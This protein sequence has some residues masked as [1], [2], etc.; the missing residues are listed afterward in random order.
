MLYTQEQ[1]QALHSQRYAFI[2]LEERDH[3]LW[4]T[5]QRPEKKNALHPV[6]I[7]ELAFA[8]HYAHFTTD[9]WTV[10]LR[11]QGDVFCAGA[12]L[13]A[14]SGDSEAV[15]S[16]VPAPEGEVLLGDM[17]QGI[18][19]PLIAQ[20]EGDVLAGGFLL[21]SSATYVVARD[22]IRLG[23]PEV[24]R[25]LFPFQ[26]MAGLLS[27]M[28]ARQVI[29]WCIRGY[30]LPAERALE[31]GLITHLATANTV[32]DM[33]DSLRQEL[34]QNSPSAIRLGLEAY[35]QIRQESTTEHHRYLLQMLM[36]TLQT[37]DA[38]EGMRAF[39]EKRP[40]V[41]TGM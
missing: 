24:K 28:P 38:Q 16:S 14:F 32:A 6:M 36:Q 3:T 19:K 35:A 17:L 13:K 30:D 2:G 20:V 10:V 9:I 39:R 23:L 8:L 37:Q 27:V 15:E 34:H 21:L 40:P 5:L 1:A 25:G 29:D 4:I 31:L 41:W 12:D 11:A 7:N 33:V 26:V 22:T 18:H